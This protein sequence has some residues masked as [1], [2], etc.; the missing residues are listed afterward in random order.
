MLGLFSDYFSQGETSI[1]LDYLQCVII[2]GFYFFN[3]WCLMAKKG[4]V[5]PEPKKMMK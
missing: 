1:T 2:G 5:S 4:M 3:S